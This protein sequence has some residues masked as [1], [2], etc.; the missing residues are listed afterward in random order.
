MM[1]S[2]SLIC[3]TSSR[4]PTTSTLSGVYANGISNGA[5]MAF[6]LSCTLSERIAAVGM[7]AAAQFLPFSWCT[8]PE[9]VPM[10]SFHGTADT[11]APYQGG[12]GW[13]S[14][15]SL[16]DVSELDRELGAPKPLPAQRH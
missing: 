2:S 3:S 7:V 10:I 11:A 4:A 12:K 6:V 9:P 1:S 13:V 16:P 14:P 15:L 5:G 8:D